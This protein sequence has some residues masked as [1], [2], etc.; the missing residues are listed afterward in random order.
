MYIVIPK[1]FMP[2]QDT[3]QLRGGIRGDAISSY[4]LMKSKLIQVVELLQKD[5]AI[6]TVVGTVGAGGGGPGGG[7]GGQC[8]SEHFAQ[9]AVAAQAECGPCH[10]KLRPQLNK[11]TGVQTFLQAVQDY[12]RRRRRRSANAQYQYTLLGDDLTELRSWSSKLRN[13]AAKRAGSRGRRY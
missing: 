8:E 2:Q 5:P 4:Q 6:A 13:G 11:I 1:G 7:G 12:R 10:R 3:G 9:A